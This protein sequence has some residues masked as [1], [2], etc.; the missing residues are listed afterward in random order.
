MSS[1]KDKIKGLKGNQN[2]ITKDPVLFGTPVKSV[3]TISAGAA[4]IDT[5]RAISAKNDIRYKRATNA[6][7]T[8]IDSS[9]LHVSC[10]KNYVNIGGC[11]WKVDR[12]G[13]NSVEP[14]KAAWQIEI[15][16]A[17]LDAYLKAK[18][19]TD[20]EINYYIPK[21]LPSETF[22]SQLSVYPRYLLG[23]RILTNL[24]AR[25]LCKVRSISGIMDV[26]D[27][28][29]PLMTSRTNYVR[30]WM[31]R[32]KFKA[33]IDEVIKA[34]NK[35]NVH[36]QTV[37][38]I[39]E[40]F[41]VQ[42]TTNGQN[43]TIFTSDVDPFP[44]YMAD[45]DWR[46]LLTVE[47]NGAT[48]N[49]LYNTAVI[50]E[51]YKAMWDDQEVISKYVTTADAAWTVYVDTIFEKALVG[52]KALSIAITSLITYYTPFESFL[53]VAQ[54]LIPNVAQKYDFNKIFE[55]QL[56]NEELV[57]PVQ[58]MVSNIGVERRTIDG[59][60]VIQ[61]YVPH[62]A[63]KPAAPF[64]DNGWLITAQASENYSAYVEL[65]APKVNILYAQPK[66]MGNKVEMF[67]SIKRDN[68]QNPLLDNV[69]T[70]VIEVQQMNGVYKVVTNGELGIS[71]ADNLPFGEY[72]SRNIH[73]GVH[74]L[75][76]EYFG[77][78]MYTTE[79]AGKDN[80]M[81]LALGQWSGF[82]NVTYQ[83]ID[84]YVVDYA[85]QMWGFK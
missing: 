35:T 30:R 54:D 81:P 22:K 1:N 23:I 43:T 18:Q 64:Q 6:I 12:T 4:F 66:N 13:K 67:K 60:E 51:I 10:G 74:H 45:K 57:L 25:T 3:Q 68:G 37:D 11:R 79:N 27:Q 78:V 84:A 77:F 21:I 29:Y 46:D 42:K 62:I 82:A 40:I 14:N 56:V 28:Q 26:L 19:M 70:H 9:P 15:E 2:V 83:P 75:L 76:S 8:S 55:H 53:Y 69:N 50:D 17:N 63:L 24:I 41:Q 85:P 32:A 20:L 80:V 16:C 34:A 36:A 72:F 65:Q 38:V 73:W 39:S 58:M 31:Q 52:I 33:A 5:G 61:A 49:L 59:Y 48:F 7:N 47:N 71:I 44:Y